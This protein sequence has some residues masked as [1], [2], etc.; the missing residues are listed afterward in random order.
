MAKKVLVTGASGFL[1]SQIVAHLVAKGKYEVRGTVRSLEKSKH[2]QKLFPQVTLYQ[3]DLLTEGSFDQAV[4]DVEVVF[5]TASPFQ[6]NIKDPKKELIEPAL[7]GTLNVLR[8]VD[9]TPSVRRVVLTSSVAASARGKP[10]SHVYSEKDWNRDS[11]ETKE[12]YPYSKTVAEEAAWKFAEGKKWKLSTILPSFI[13]GAPLSDRIDAVSVQAV[14]N[15]LE[16]KHHEKEPGL[17]VGA[18]SIHDIATAHILAAEKNEAINQRY[19]VT[20]TRSYSRQDLND[21]LIQ[22]GE[23]KNFPL[24][25]NIFVKSKGG[26]NYDNSKVQ[27]ELGLQFSP[28]DKTVVEMGKALVKLNIVKLPS[29][30]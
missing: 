24:D 17:A 8:S 13:L 27:R 15:L 30:L 11:T 3:A 4:K 5:H 20:S 9:K 2:L 6:T 18:V 23:F 29:K 7:Q 28:V 25:K 21:L 12:P 19:F 26:F 14:K 22:S 16:G 1:A 10:P